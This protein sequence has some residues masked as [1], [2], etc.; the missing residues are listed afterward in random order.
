MTAG[1]QY[2]GRRASTRRFAGRPIRAERRHQGARPGDRQDDVDVP[3]DQ[4]SLT[5]G[6]PRRRGTCSLPRRATGPDRTRFEDRHL[7]RQTGG[8][9]AASPMSYAVDG[10]QYVALAERRRRELRRRQ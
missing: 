8:D 2:R 1:Q 4:G 10:R 3:A 7:W 5:N 6:V 9:H